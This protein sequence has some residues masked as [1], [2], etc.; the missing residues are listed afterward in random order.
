MMPLASTAFLAISLLAYYGFDRAFGAISDS[1]YF[2]FNYL[3]NDGID[4]ENN[5]EMRDQ[6]E[7][8]FFC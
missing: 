3:E 8:Y 6:I 7:G 4:Y 1:P 2:N 5:G